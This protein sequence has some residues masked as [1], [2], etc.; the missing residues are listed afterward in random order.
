MKGLTTKSH[1]AIAACYHLSRLTQKNSVSVK[2]L[3]ALLDVSAAYLEQILSKLKHAKILKS[4][5]GA[6]GGFS[7]DKSL[8]AIT[9]LDIIKVVEPGFAMTKG[10]KHSSKVVE[11]FWE[12]IQKQVVMLFDKK[13]TELDAEF[14]PLMYEI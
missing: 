11:F 1:Y 13:L 7:F 14:L 8:N 10:I 4:K 12:D 9:I 6:Q 2:E 5:R 3:A